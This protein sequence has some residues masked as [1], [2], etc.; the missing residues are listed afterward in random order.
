[1]E[2]INVSKARIVTVFETI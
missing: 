2:T 1:M